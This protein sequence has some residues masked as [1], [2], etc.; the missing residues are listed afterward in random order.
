LAIPEHPNLARF[1]TFDAGAKPK[2]V[3]VMELI[4]GTTC[5]KLI[6]SRTLSLGL[7]VS[8]L[9]GTLAGLGA[10][11]GV[12]LAHLDLKPANVILRNGREAV[13]VDFGLAGRH[14]RPGCGSGG[15]GA[16]EVWL[17]EPSALAGSPM[18]ADLYGFGCLAYEVLTGKAL[19]DAPSEV[20]LISAHT[21]HA[22][23]PYGVPRLAA[24]AA[25]EPLA[26]LLFDCLRHD[27]AKRPAATKV[28]ADLRALSARLSGLR[29]PL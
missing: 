29:W 5:E 13:L 17:A 6:T 28:R 25:L 18:P 1:V 14:L 3:L 24:N 11:H 22:G 16:P 10:M 2:P 8:L 7:A 12:G 27:P 19:F 21:P 4:E 20:E 23:C 9:D 15:F 26:M